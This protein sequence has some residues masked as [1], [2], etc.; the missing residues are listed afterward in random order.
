MQI[1]HDIIDFIRNLKPVLES[2]INTYGN[3]VYGFLWAIVF[4]ET[5]LVIFP[6]LP[7]DS[8]LFTAGV[9][10]QGKLNVWVLS[11]VFISAAVV[12]DNVNYYLGKTFGA[13]AFGKEN[14]KIFKKSYLEATNRFFEKHGPKTLIYARFVPFVRTFAP[15]V[16]GMGAMAYPRFLATSFLAAA[17]WVFVCVFAGFFFGKIPAVE[18]N[19]ELAIIG[20]IAISI[21]PP[22]G[23]IIIQRMKKKRATRTQA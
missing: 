15:F 4:C 3:W 23:E 8:L 7:G 1:L 20:I 14:S 10:A 6:F 21:L 19:F 16:A 11:F 22:I 5:G 12:G 18:E 13:K 2:W 9:L 17:I